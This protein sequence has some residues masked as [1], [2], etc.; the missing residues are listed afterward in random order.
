MVNQHIINQFIK[1]YLFDSIVSVVLSLLALQK[2]FQQAIAYGCS[3][4]LA[5]TIAIF[6]G[7]LVTQFY[8]FV[9]RRIYIKSMLF[10]YKQFD[11]VI[12]RHIERKGVQRW[13]SQQKDTLVNDAYAELPESR[14]KKLL[15]LGLYI[16][17]AEKLI[18]EEK[19]AEADKKLSC[20]MNYT[21]DTLFMLG[22]DAGDVYKICNLV[23]FFVTTRSVIQSPDSITRHEDISMAEIKNFV[24]N[25]A[26]PYG[27]DN[28]TAARFVVEVF[29]EWCV[30]TDYQGNVQRTEVSTI[31]KTLRSTKG[32]LR[33]LPESICLKTAD[34]DRS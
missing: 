5:L 15:D 18:H 21:K 20:V 34:K 3:F 9:F 22:F 7:L 1:H 24:A 33:V 27:I 6:A 28:L 32:K 25:I 17:K 14:K 30:W 31:A 19:K 8:W 12:I 29:K 11:R 2:V 13:I 23:E 26:N 4:R 16:Y 10:L